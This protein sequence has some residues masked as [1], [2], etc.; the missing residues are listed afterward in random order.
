M[1]H[2]S[3]VASPQRWQMALQRAFHEGVRVY[4]SNLTGDWIAT[5]GT[6]NG[7]FYELQV[8]RGGMFATCSCDAGEHNDPVC[9]HLAM[10]HFNAGNL[11]LDEFV[12]PI[13]PKHRDGIMQA[14]RCRG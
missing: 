12:V 1:D 11:E 2:R 10:F 7:K 5:S 3:K 13:P 4:Q 14:V 6:T 8:Y 9:K